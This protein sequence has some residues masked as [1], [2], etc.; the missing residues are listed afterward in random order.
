MADPVPPAERRPWRFGLHT[1]LLLLCTLFLG[2]IAADR[3]YEQWIK[4][5]YVEFIRAS[6]AAS[7]SRSVVDGGT[8]DGP[9]REAAL[10]VYY[11]MRDRYQSDFRARGL[12]HPD[13]WN[14]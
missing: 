5:K 11:E 3:V 13:K 8:K 14:R 4:M 7:A 9:D 6:N 2:V 1:L 12:P 10:K